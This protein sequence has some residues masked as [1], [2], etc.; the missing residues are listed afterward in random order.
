[1]VRFGAKKEESFL[2]FYFTHI[3]AFR[4]F[5]I[6]SKYFLEKSIGFQKKCILAEP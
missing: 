6:S 3:G 1:M 5:F 4:S 2:L